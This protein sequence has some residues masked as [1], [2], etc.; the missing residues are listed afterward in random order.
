MMNLY[1]D[2][3]LAEKYTSR[4]QMARVLTGT[5]AKANMYCPRCGYPQLTRFQN[6]CKVADFFCNECKNE[7][8]LKSRNGDI[9]HK[10][11]DGAYD[12][13][14][15]RITSANNPDFF[16]MSYDLSELRVNN[17]WV[18]PKYF[19]TPSIVEKRK[20]L[21]SEARRA[22][23][24]G[25]NILFDE[26]P[27]QGKIYVVRNGVPINVDDVV[28]SVKKSSQ[29]ETANL[30]ARGWLLDTLNCVNKISKEVFSLKEI[31]QFENELKA[32]HPENKNIQAKIRQQLQIL[33]DKGCLEFLE[34]GVYRKKALH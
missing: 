25:C 4:S 29:L 23:W 9:G 34:R 15:Q 11:M 20:K 21:S 31:Y 28:E 12:T 19:F 8:E 10:I 30:D 14:V 13:F 32:R 17:L 33:R 18:V 27:E 24:I 6:N 7:Y 26:V 16:V 3:T 5:W 2:R 22:G 1:F